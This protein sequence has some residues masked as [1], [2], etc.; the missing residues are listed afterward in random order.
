MYLTVFITKSYKCDN[1]VCKC[2]GVT[3]W[4]RP[5]RKDIYPI[6][7]RLVNLHYK[8]KHSSIPRYL[9]INNIY[10]HNVSMW[11]CRAFSLE[12]TYLNLKFTISLI[13]FHLNIYY[14]NILHVLRWLIGRV[15][16]HTCTW[17]SSAGRVRG[18][19][20]L[21]LIEIKIHI[22]FIDSLLL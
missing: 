16:I 10:K 6:V 15:S 4:N 7:L 13:S 22:E 11:I 14:A 19:T 21:H 17:Q 12:W 1:C 3:N 5:I 8:T 20:I 18:T 9:G 2:M